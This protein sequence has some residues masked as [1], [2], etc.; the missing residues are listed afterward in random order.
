MIVDLI[1]N[2][3]KILVIGGGKE[4]LKRIRSIIKEQCEIIIISE[5]ISEQIKNIAKTKKIVIKKQK[6]TNLQFIAEY[7]PDI[8]ITTTDNKELNQKIINAAK[9]RKILVYSSDN[10][11]NSDFSNPAIMDFEDIIKIAIFTG[12]SSPI[13]AKKIKEKSEEIFK[14]TIT[15]E[16]IGQAKI[17]KKI[18]KVVKNVISSQKQRKR[19]M[20]SIMKNNEIDQLIKD[21]KFKKAENRAISMMRDWK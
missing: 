16:D 14:K 15:K 19:Y 3:K 21:G 20:E 9:K 2:Q 1:I 7:K 13:I 5:T 11:D 17:H 4:A 6:I 8:I 18:R 12:G 10:P